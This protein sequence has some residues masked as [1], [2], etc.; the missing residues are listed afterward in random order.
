MVLIVQQI[1]LS[2]LMF[3]M[4]MTAPM[5]ISTQ[6]TPS[7]VCTSDRVSCVFLLPLSLVVALVRK[8]MRACRSLAKKI[9]C[10][11][12]FMA[13]QVNLLQYSLPSA[14]NLSLLSVLIVHQMLAMSVA[15]RLLPLSLVFALVRKRFLLCQSL[16]GKTLIPCCRMATILVSLQLMFSLAPKLRCSISFTLVKF[17]VGTVFPIPNIFRWV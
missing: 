16:V 14:P 3:S 15:Y 7:S 2:L 13:T 17:L 10:R 6:M 9:F 5:I 4:A 1:S 8:L 12:C 11:C